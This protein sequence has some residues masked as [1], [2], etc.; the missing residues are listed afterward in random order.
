MLGA[1]L[2]AA[3]KAHE[4]ARH[5]VAFVYYLRWMNTALVLG[6]NEGGPA[7]T[8]RGPLR[9]PYVALPYGR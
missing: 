3:V 7:T 9:L 5:E 2:E 8:P 1:M 4:G 6:L